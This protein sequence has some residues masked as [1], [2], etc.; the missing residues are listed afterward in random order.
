MASRNNYTKYF[1]NSISK[2]L[3]RAC[4]GIIF[5][6]GFWFSKTKNMENAINNKKLFSIFY[7]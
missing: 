4:L 7:S 1:K 3:L 6:N 2:N 5:E